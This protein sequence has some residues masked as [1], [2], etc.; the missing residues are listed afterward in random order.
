M[1][2]K[3]ILTI[4]LTALLFVSV[5]ILGVSSTFRVDRVTVEFTLLS[6]EGKADSQTMQA[7][8]TQAYKG[9]SILSLKE[10]EARAVLSK[11]SYFRM[12]AFEKKSP[13]KLYIQ[14]VEDGETY[15]VQSGNEYYIVSA[16]GIIV[17]KRNTLFNRLDG[18]ENLLVKG[19]TATG[20][21]GGVLSG[22]DC[23]QSMLAFCGELDTRL[24]G[25]RKNVVAAE[26]FKRTPEIFF[27]IQMREGVAIYVSSPQSLTEEKAKKA[28]NAY[29]GLSDEAR[30][31]GSLT[32]FELNGEVLAEYKADSN[33]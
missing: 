28:F 26:V 22:D 9:K 29:M 2:K 25:I 19:V 10:E 30:T 3:R 24:G 12:T 4:V 5:V 18:Q 20:D 11:Y 16:E 31:R 14:I 32:V 1:K 33:F 23:W 13:D 17:E 6:E 7:E 15:A 27:R 21:K 8:L